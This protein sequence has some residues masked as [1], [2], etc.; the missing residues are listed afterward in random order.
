MKTLK[1]P[2]LKLLIFLLLGI[3]SGYTFEIELQYTLYLLSSFII[4]SLLFSYHKKIA[5]STIYSLLLLATVFLIGVLNATIHSNQNPEHYSK[6]YQ[7]GDSIFLK[8]SKQLKHS[9]YYYK[10]EA[11]VY[12]INNKKSN[13]NI[14]LNLVRDS[15]SEK[16]LPKTDF[17]YSTNTLLKEVNAPLNPHQF[18]YKKYL[19]TQQIYHQLTTKSHELKRIPN[20]YKTIRG[21]AAIF[22]ET[23]NKKLSKYPYKEEIAVVN[24]LLLGQRQGISKDVY[25]EYAAAGAIHLLAISGLHIGILYLLLSFLLKPLNRIKHGK[26]I[27]VIIIITL[28][29]IFAIIAGLSPSIVR[30]VTMFTFI[31]YAEKLNRAK[32]INLALIGSMFILLL[33]KPSFIFDVGF[34]LSYV[35]VFGIVWIQPT[36]VALWSPRN[37]LVLYLWKLLTVS[38]AAQLS[39]LPLTLY[40]FHQFPGLFFISNLVIVPFIGMLLGFG[41]VIIILALLNILPNFIA[42]IYFTII[43]I[44]NLLIGWIANQEDFIFRKIYFTGANLI[45]TSILII[46]LVILLKNYSKRNLVM[47][48]GSFLIFSSTI[49]YQNHQSQ[50]QSKFTLFHRTRISLSSIQKGR[51]LQVNDTSV[52]TKNIIKAYSI[53]ENIKTISHLKSPQTFQLKKKNFTIIDSTNVYQKNKTD[54]LILTYSPKINLERVLFQLKPNKVIADGSNYKSFIKM[55]RASCIKQKIPFHY[56]GEKGAFILD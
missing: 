34:Q 28:L 48:I 46:A 54:L 40:Y 31:A 20:S 19:A 35:A 1:Y 16:N 24:A 11:N 13:G 52:A 55:W 43:K 3:Y 51:S 38:V 26:T 53:G 50:L 10:Y 41:F 45:T 42:E 23:I 32:N 27:G 22:R 49:L 7:L 14:I 36:L 9:D 56:T 37:K 17:E 6:K 2:I 15:I 39:V 25:Q 30:S 4:V 12:R 5:T 18:D 21:Y 44:M 8:I 29:W 47:G 33:F